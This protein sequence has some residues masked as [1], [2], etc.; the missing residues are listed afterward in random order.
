MPHEKDHD[1]NPAI[2]R[3][4]LYKVSSVFH[5]HHFAVLYIRI[6]E[7]L[8]SVE[9]RRILKKA[10][11]DSFYHLLHDYFTRGRI[12]DLAPRIEAA[13]RYWQLAGMGMIRFVEVGKYL[14]RAEMSSSHVDLGWLQHEGENDRPINH[15]STGFVA[16]CAALFNDLPVESYCCRETQSL[17]CGDEISAFRAILK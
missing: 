15:I 17:A 16:A 10:A 7:N 6:A 12:N 4:F 8:M 14:V 9:G 11:E 13:E 1:F 5:C 2:S 3:H